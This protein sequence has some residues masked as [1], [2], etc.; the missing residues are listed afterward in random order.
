MTFGATDLPGRGVE[1]LQKVLR[2][3]ATPTVDGFDDTSL[4]AVSR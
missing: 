3:D 1:D 2:A 4:L